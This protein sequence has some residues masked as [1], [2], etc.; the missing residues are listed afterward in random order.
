MYLLNDLAFS[1]IDFVIYFIFR[2]QDPGGNEFLYNYY[3]T[4]YWVLQNY[5]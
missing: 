4:I 5:D 1:N 2:K 3:T